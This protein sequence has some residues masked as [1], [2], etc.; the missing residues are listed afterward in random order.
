M[1]E[2]GRGVRQGC[3]AGS[4]EIEGMRARARSLFTSTCAAVAQETY[5]TADRWGYILAQWFRH[6]RGTI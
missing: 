5:M 3:E 4:R 6:G 1:G 2:G